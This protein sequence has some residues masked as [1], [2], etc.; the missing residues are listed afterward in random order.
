MSPTRLLNSSSS[1]GWVTRFAENG[2]IAFMQY[3]SKDRS[4]RAAAG[5][6]CYPPAMLGSFR[7]LGVGQRGQPVEYPTYSQMDALFLGQER[8]E[9]RLERTFST[10]GP[11]FVLD[12]PLV[13]RLPAS[14]P[15]K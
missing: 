1:M 6:T 10:A 15:A 13:K 3:P 2:K 9:T 14:L 7:H 4:Y 8:M 11:S 5:K 12:C